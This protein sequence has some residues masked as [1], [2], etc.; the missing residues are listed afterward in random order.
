M[1]SILFA[2]GIL[3]LDMFSGSAE[4]QVGRLRSSGQ[5]CLR[6]YEDSGLNPPHEVSRGFDGARNYNGSEPIVLDLVCPIVG[7]DVSSFFAPVKVWAFIND[8]STTGSVIC[9]WTGGYWNGFQL[10]HVNSNT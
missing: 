1:K 9:T 6:R 2:A 10:T 4:A 3:T 8:T 5:A 7:F